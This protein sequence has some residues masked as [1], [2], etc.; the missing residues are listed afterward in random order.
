MKTACDAVGMGQPRSRNARALAGFLAT[1]GTLHFTVPQYFDALVP[2]GLPGPARTWT[3]ASGAAELL[4]AAAVAVPAT[5]RAGGLAAVALFMAVLPANV[6][7]VLDWRTKPL[8]HRA[9]A[10]GRLPLQV[11]LVL[12]ALRASRSR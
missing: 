7:M 9:V 11:P 6:Q 8:A 2:R 3:H 1:M 10:W 5:R 12:W 4:V